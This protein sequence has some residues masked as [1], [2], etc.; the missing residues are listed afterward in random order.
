MLLKLPIILLAV[1][2][3]HPVGEH[4]TPGEGKAGKVFSK[5]NLVAWCIVPYDNKKRGAVER[6]EMLSK[7]G[8]TKFAYDWR[9]EHI[10]SA[11][12]EMDVLKQHHIKLQA[13]WMPY[14]PNPAGNKHYDELFT[15][16]ET[17][18]L[19]TQLWWSYGSSDEGLKNKSQEEKVKYVGDMVKMMATRAAK[20]GCTV[21]LYNHNGW[22]GEPENL[23]AILAYVNMPNTGI[24]Y[25]FN[26]AEDQIDRFPAFFPKILPHLVALNIAGLK[27]GKPGKIVPVG[28]GDSEQEMIRIIAESSY[29]GPVGIINEDTDPDAQT[30]LTMNM[31][32]LK[33][34][35][36]SLGYTEA[37]QTYNNKENLTKQVL[38]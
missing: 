3:T 8:I 20:N 35:L 34:I 2:I 30:G 10:L 29:C 7:L 25:N 6:A 13:C 37:L 21:G 4:T 19:K 22:F 14:G 28:K 18:A 16:L 11:G 12:N 26:H 31:A 27:N 9:E 1:L 33:N 23:L 36:Q 38:H 5:S 32:G 17:R 15:Q 24:V